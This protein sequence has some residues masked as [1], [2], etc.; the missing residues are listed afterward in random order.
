MVKRLTDRKDFR[1]P[2]LYE[3]LTLQFDIDEYGSN[4][5]SNSHRCMQFVEEDYYDRLCE[6]PPPPH[7]SFSR[8]AVQAAGT[9]TDAQSTETIQVTIYCRL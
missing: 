4:F 2:A 7:V 9:G 8:G 1:N 5:G 3:K 6:C